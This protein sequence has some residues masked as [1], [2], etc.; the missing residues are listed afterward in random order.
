MTV[1][2]NNTNISDEFE[3][4]LIQLGIFGFYVFSDCYVL[5]NLVNG[6]VFQKYKTPIKVTTICC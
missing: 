5:I 6:S 3:R 1:N 4:T 2:I